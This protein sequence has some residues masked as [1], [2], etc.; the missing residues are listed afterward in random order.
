M[1]L[2]ALYQYSEALGIVSEEFLEHHLQVPG[3]AAESSH[4]LAY[5]G[6]AKIATEL[7][8]EKIKI[9][10][11]FLT[12]LLSEEKPGS[13]YLLSCLVTTTYG[14]QMKKN[15]MIMVT[16]TVCYKNPQTQQ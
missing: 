16:S 9:K 14:L 13:G 10:R 2:P 1:S 5:L 8:S 7:W 3:A 12:P 4:T 6:N 15:G 11:K